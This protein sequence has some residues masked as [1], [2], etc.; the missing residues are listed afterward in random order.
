M[1]FLV[2]LFRFNSYGR[3]C[4]STSKYESEISKK[5]GFERFE[6]QLKAKEQIENCNLTQDSI[7]LN[8]FFEISEY[9][10]YQ[11]ILNIH[12]DVTRTATQLLKI[13]KFSN[14]NRLRLYLIISQSLGMNNRNIQKL[15][16]LKNILAK[17]ENIIID[18]EKICGVYEELIAVSIQQGDYENALN[19]SLRAL[20]FSQNNHIANFEIQFKSLQ[21]KIQILIGDEDGAIFNLN[22]AIQLA[23]KTNS[24]DLK[25]SLLRT[26]GYYYSRQ[27]DFLKSL[28]AFEEA[29]FML[30]KEQTP[31]MDLDIGYVNYN[32]LANYDEALKYYFSALENNTKD[33]YLESRLFD[34]IGACFWKKKDYK[35]ALKYYQNGLT[36]FK[37][38]NFE[39]NDPIFLPTSEK[40]KNLG[41][42]DFFLTLFEDKAIC[43]LDYYKATTT[44]S[45]LVHALETYELADNLVDYMRQEHTGTLSKYFW[46]NKTRSLYENAIETSY[47]LKDYEKAYYYMEKSRAVMLN[48]KLNELGAKQKLNEADQEKEREYQRKIIELN[49]KIEAETKAVAKEKLNSQLFDLQEQQERFVK[50]LETKYPAYYQ[51]KYNTQIGTLKQMQA[52][53]KSNFKGQTASMVSYFFGDS[54]SYGMVISPT[55]AEIKQFKYDAAQ[56]QAF[57]NLLAGNQGTKTEFAQLLSSGSN[58]YEKLIKPLNIPKGHLIISQDGVFLPFEAL[59]TSANNAHYLLNDYAI[60]YTYSGQFLLKKQKET[61]FWPNQTFVGFA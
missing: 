61:K 1:I 33:Q 4:F 50:S 38:I 22:S 37:L 23:Q 31:L 29:K 56:N 5:V 14:L 58:I 52:Y 59:S 12:N 36:S 15:K 32:L 47:L 10:Y 44:K 16:F 55:K 40:F 46:R 21:S 60:S 39:K 2:F 3:K 8:I 54:A 19:F 45:H 41:L 18:K 9:S 42:K 13:H 48:D 35:T 34:N 17:F 43:W 26:K 6:F 51:L 24:I 20:A 49:T 11:N 53:L 25:V 30:P 28:K 57:V 27:K 7:Y